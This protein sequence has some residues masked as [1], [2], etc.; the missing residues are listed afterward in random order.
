VINFLLSKSLLPTG[1]PPS[2]LSAGDLGSYFTDKTKAHGCES[3]HLHS[4]KST[5]TNF[6]SFV[7]IKDMSLV[8]NAMPEFM[9]IN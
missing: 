5:C 4:T 1:L 8:S 9:M 2:S 3:L 6:L 7:K